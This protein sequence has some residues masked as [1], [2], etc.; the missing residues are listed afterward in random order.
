MRSSACCCGPGALGNVSDHSVR[1]SKKVREKGSDG[2]VKAVN[3]VKIAV[4][5]AAKFAELPTAAQAAP[6]TIEGVEP[7]AGGAAEGHLPSSAAGPARSTA[8]KGG[9]KRPAKAT[10]SSGPSRTTAATKAR[11][12]PQSQSAAARVRPRGAYFGAP[13]KSRPIPTNAF[14][15]FA[16]AISCQ[17]S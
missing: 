8:Q 13:C 6:G 2:L 1:S 10:L 15:N 5:V 4:S 17:D 7:C 16:P 11:A 3:D 14:P 9:D 12:P